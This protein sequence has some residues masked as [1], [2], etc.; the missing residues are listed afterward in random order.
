MK[1][2]L[3]IS[4]IIICVLAS[5]IILDY[6][7]S[8][9]IKIECYNAIP[10]E[11]YSDEYRISETPL[12]TEED[13]EYYDWKQHIIVFK[14]KSML[15]LSRLGGLEHNHQT[16]SSFA[17]TPRDK[18]YLYV[19]EELIYTGYYSQSRISSFYAEGITMENIEN[20]VLIKKDIKK[21]GSIDNRLNDRLYN[22]L[23]KNKILKNRF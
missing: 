14:E 3:I 19:D 22:A 2:K 7:N 23:K 16:L 1:R 21:S 17:T 15:K 12:F 4:T 13:I 10:I 8:S 18:F 11:S 9:Q 20:G 6:K 5:Y